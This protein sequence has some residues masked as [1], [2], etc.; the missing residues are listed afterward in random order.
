MKPLSIPEFKR[1]LAGAPLP[2]DGPPATRLSFTVQKRARGLARP[3]ATRMGARAVRMYDPKSNVDA[4]DDVAKAFLAATDGRHNALSDSPV[5]LTVIASYSTPRKKLWGT[6]KLTRP[7]ADNLVKLVAD[8]LNGIAY[9]DDSQIV[10][11]HV[12]KRWADK[13]EFTVHLEWQHEGG[14]A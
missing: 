9:G 5:V 3:K 13:S 10:E 12:Y 7:D 2:A 8:A 11:A 14:R 4:K 6:P 1:V